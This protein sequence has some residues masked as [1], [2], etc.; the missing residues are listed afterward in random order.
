MNITSLTAQTNDTADRWIALLGHFNID[1][2]LRK[3]DLQS[4]SLGQVALHIVAETGFYL[5]QAEDC[6]HSN[7]NFSGE[8]TEDAKT[9]F[10]Q[11]SFPDIRIRRDASLSQFYPQPES[12]F[13][14]LER[15]KQL[16]VQLNKLLKQM[17]TSPYSGKTRHP[18]LGYFNARQWIQF[19]EMHMR[20]HLK[21]KDRIEAALQLS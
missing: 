20:H 18:G 10:D 13:D 15:M 21:Q 17:K 12:Q 11:N 14:I 2:L 7:E 1:I 19:A 8:M 6:L 5:K 3:P 16:K 4:W 9:M